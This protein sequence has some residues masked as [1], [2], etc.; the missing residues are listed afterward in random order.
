ML[1]LFLLKITKDVSYHQLMD[2][3]DPLSV[4]IPALWDHNVHQIA[5]LAYSIPIEVG[6]PF[7][8]ILLLI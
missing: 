4:L 3:T 2:G 6:F 7:I 5:K 8:T 1:L